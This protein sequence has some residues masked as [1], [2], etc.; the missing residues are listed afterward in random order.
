MPTG[1]YERKKVELSIDI[2]K[3]LVNV[4]TTR[5]I[6]VQ[7]LADVFYLKCK[8][9][10]NC[11][12]NNGV[13]LGCDKYLLTIDQ[14]TEI[15]EKYKSGFNTPELAKEY[16]VSTDSLQRSLK[17]HGFVLRTQAESCKKHWNDPEF[18]EFCAKRTTGDKSP[19]WNGGTTTL[20]SKLRN[21]SKG[22][23]WRKSVFERDNYTCQKCGSEDNLNA[24]HIREF[25]SMVKEKNITSVEQS[26]LY[27]ELWDISNG[28]T[29]C[30]TCHI[31]HHRP[32]QI[33]HGR[34]C[35]K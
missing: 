13:V 18:K 19:N 17:R 15:Y 11:L 20:L 2:Q 23:S 12:V 16:K 26:R 35:K 32:L 1:V 21:S 28:E 8:Q 3:E 14:L 4:Y 33:K 5:K 22:R 34:Y 25:D 7:K 10:R 29:L 27:P 30:R 31:E 6:T 24:H 9:V